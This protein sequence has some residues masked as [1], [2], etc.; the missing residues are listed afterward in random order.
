M[1]PDRQPASESTQTNSTVTARQQPAALCLAS[2]DDLWSELLAQNLEARGVRTVRC[3]VPDLRSYTANLPEGS[4][5]VIDGGWPMLELQN[6]ITELNAALRQSHLS[7]V[8]VVDELV[9]SHPLAEFKPDRVISR[10]ADMR[11]FVP[12]L[13]NIVQSPSSSG[14]APVLSE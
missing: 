12:E 2:I 1:S 6:S 7:T 14:P 11:V 13:L 4:W 8:L 9:G 5:V 10:S 3:R